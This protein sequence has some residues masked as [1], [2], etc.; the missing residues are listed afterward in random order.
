M[1]GLIS[2]AI[3]SDPGFPPRWV[4]RSL[5]QLVRALSAQGFKTSQ[6][7]ITDLLRD[8]EFIWQAEPQNLERRQAL[9]CAAPFARMSGTVKVGEPVI[10]VGTKELQLG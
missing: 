10:S 5:H 3:C 2:N 7:R 6:R 1:V 9:A 8:P 4:S